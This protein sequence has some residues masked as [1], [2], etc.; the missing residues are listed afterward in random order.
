L[1]GF[2]NTGLLRIEIEE[3]E[4]DQ[5]LKMF[6]TQKSISGGFAS[7][8]LHFDS[9]ISTIETSL[10][11]VVAAHTGTISLNTYKARKRAEIKDRTAELEKDLTFTYATHEYHLSASYQDKWVNI[12]TLSDAG[13]IVYP[14]AISSVDGL[15]H[16][17]NDH[18]E[19]TAFVGAGLA[20][21]EAFFA[22][23]DQYF[24]DIDAATT[25]EAVDAV[26]DTR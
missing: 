15:L 16:D 1:T 6:S 3:L 21:A 19:V 14:K 20:A 10:D 7:L 5:K 12:F 9:D 18:A 2:P 13:L 4:I 11:T 22:T 8:T 25:L 23:D 17:L 24:I 26:V